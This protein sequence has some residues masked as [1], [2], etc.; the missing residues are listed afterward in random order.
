VLLRFWENPE[1]VRHLRAELR[2]PRAITAA[3]L[4]LVIIILVGLWAWGV[5]HKDAPAFAKTLHLALVVMQ[6]T[7]LGFWCASACGQAV[8]RERELKTF[9]FLKTTR[10][11][12]GEILVGKLLGTPMVVYF[13]VA[14]SLPVSFVTGLLAG[15][16]LSKMVWVVA[17]LAAFGLFVGLIG[18]WVS[19]LVQKSGAGAAIVI[20]LLPMAWLMGFS[21]T[22]FSGFSGLSIVSS[23]TSLYR[24]S[25]PQFDQPPAVLGMVVPYP[26][27]TVALYVLFGAWFVLMLVRNLKKDREQMRLLTRWQAVGLVA[28]LN[29]LLY[30]F[31]DPNQLA[32]ASARGSL[33][34]SGAA[35]LAVGFNAL[36]MLLLGIATLTPHERLKIWW[37]RRAAGQASYFHSDGPSWP[38][39]AVMG[40]IA[41]ALLAAEAAGW[42]SVIPVGRWRLGLAALQLLAVVI[43][44]ARDVLFLQWCLLTRLKRPVWKGFLYLMLYYTATGIVGGVSMVFS[45]VSGRFLLGMLTPWMVLGSEGAADPTIGL[46][47]GLALQSALILL[48]LRAISRR[49]SRPAVAPAPSSATA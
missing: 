18:L 22:P 16:P 36:L 43:Y 7:L 5:E 24:D 49:L 14:C 25:K 6:F 30:V 34:P 29:V 37:R 4:T 47:P 17:L 40:A 20:A 11:S 13:V 3:L 27:L 42:S 44:V 35:T 32:G 39:V 1:F 28:F 23:L 21:S 9:D 10:L 31:L 15:Y 33:R 2:P 19:I 26:P 48:L 46:Y 8:S 41:Y 38:Y 45:E 12:P